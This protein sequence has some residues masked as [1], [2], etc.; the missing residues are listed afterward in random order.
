M[1]QEKC[2]FCGSAKLVSGKFTTFEDPYTGFK[3]NESIEPLFRLR[4]VAG[5]KLPQS[6]TFCANCYMVWCKADSRDAH[7]YMRDHADQSLKERLLT[8]DGPPPPV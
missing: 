2:P 8:A 1:T 4:T 6:A 3:P 7:N 5:F